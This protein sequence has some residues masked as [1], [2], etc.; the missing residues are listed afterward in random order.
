VVLPHLIVFHEECE[1]RT[2]EELGATEFEAA[3][4]QGHTLRFDEAVA[5]ALRESV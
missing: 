2:R 5:Y 4:R 3:R 1:R